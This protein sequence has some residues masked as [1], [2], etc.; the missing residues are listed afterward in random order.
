MRFHETTYFAAACLRCNAAGLYAATQE[1]ALDDAVGEE[2]WEYRQ[3]DV[4]CPKCAEKDPPDAK[5]TKKG[6]GKGKG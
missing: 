4:I 1:E 6:K 2:G 3:G 5:D